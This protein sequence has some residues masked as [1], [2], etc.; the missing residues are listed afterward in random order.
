VC[1]ARNVRTPAQ[2]AWMTTPKTF[3]PDSAAPRMARRSQTIIRC[4]QCEI[5]GLIAPS[6]AS[7][8]QRVHVNS[9]RRRRV[10]NHI[11]IIFNMGASA[12]QS[13][14]ALN[15]KRQAAPASPGSQSSRGPQKGRSDLSSANSCGHSRGFVQYLKHRRCNR[16]RVVKRD[17]SN[18]PRIEIDKQRR[19]P[20]FAIA[21]TN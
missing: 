8:H 5:C 18:W 16:A 7:R 12:P 3:K 15:C 20:R 11:L 9:Q 14:T 13:S 2:K 19:F 4:L 21:A 10:Q 1:V 6:G 17:S